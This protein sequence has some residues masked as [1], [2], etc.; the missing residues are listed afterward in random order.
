MGEMLTV[1]RRGA[2]GGGVPPAAH[3]SR[4]AIALRS[5]KVC[6]PVLIG[7]AQT[8]PGF[9]WLVGRNIV[10][11]HSATDDRCPV[12]VPPV[13]R[14]Y[15]SK[16]AVPATSHS[17][18]RALSAWRACSEPTSVSVLKTS[19]GTSRSSR[20][21]VGAWPVTGAGT[22]GG[23]ARGAPPAPRLWTRKPSYTCARGCA[24]SM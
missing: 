1:S 3:R 14:P 15:W 19:T 13:N 9:G 2:L 11:N 16:W 24:A 21:N 5:T 4:W 22:A 12:S 7:E 23:C 18:Y 17:R 6:G 20:M 8:N 10:S